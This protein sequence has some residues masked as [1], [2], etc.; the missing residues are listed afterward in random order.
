MHYGVTESSP[1]TPEERY[2]YASERWYGL[3]DKAERARIDNPWKRQAYEI[4]NLAVD[5]RS[6]VDLPREQVVAWAKENLGA[7]FDDLDDAEID[8]AEVLTCALESAAF[9]L[10][11]VAQRLEEA[12]WPGSTEVWRR[13]VNAQLVRIIYA[14]TKAPARR[15][16]LP[17]SSR[18]RGRRPRSRRRART[19]TR[20]ATGDDEHDGDDRPPGDDRSVDDALLDLLREVG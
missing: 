17:A 6:I 7:A 13:Q 11:E 10:L 8:A 3:V 19:P 9:E 18:P 1:P 16:P 4:L 12:V 14:P 2:A 20:L 15:R 5:A